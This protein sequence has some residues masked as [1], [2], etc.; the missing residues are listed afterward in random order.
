M[1]HHLP[2]DS[3]GAFWIL[4][5]L[6]SIF[7]RL[8]WFSVHLTA[9]R[10]GTL[11]LSSSIDSCELVLLVL[12]ITRCIA[13]CESY[14]IWATGSSS[15]NWANLGTV[16][17]GGLNSPFMRAIYT[18][19]EWWRLKMRFLRAILTF[20]WQVLFTTSIFSV[21][22]CAHVHP[23]CDLPKSSKGLS[24]VNALILIK[25]PVRP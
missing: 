12:M 8:S 22:Y 11:L 21:N 16:R 19:G 15:H 2:L 13:D 9:V 1:M 14:R 6:R 17:S 18:D 5:T 24:L 3:W 10:R 20:S 25:L 4:H 23:L 7:Q